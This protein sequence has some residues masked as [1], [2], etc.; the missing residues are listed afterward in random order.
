MI[1]RQQLIEWAVAA[2][3]SGMRLL[4]SCYRLDCGHELCDSF[5]RMVD[6]IDSDEDLIKVREEML[7]EANKFA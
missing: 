4:V 5:N 1:E 6:R 3:Q 7:A 2:R